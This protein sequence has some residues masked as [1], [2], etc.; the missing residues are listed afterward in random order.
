[1]DVGVV[2]GCIPY[3]SCEVNWIVS[4]RYRNS[5]RAEVVGQVPFIGDK[6]GVEDGVVTP[7]D[8]LHRIGARLFFLVTGR[9]RILLC[10]VNFCFGA[11]IR[12]EVDPGPGPGRRSKPPPQLPGRPKPG[13]PRKR[14]NFWVSWLMFLPWY[15]VLLLVVRFLL[16][17]VGV[18]HR[19]LL[20]LLHWLILPTLPVNPPE[21][22]RPPGRR[23]KLPGPLNPIWVRPSSGPTRNT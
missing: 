15:S 20:V 11:P 19:A 4:C 6:E 3:L 16:C 8:I 14:S 7:A 1:M 5:W 23:V 22:P 21:P 13:P 10:Y 17:A 2:S 12:A 9:H 18:A